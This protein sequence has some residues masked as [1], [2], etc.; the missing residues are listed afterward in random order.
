MNWYVSTTADLNIEMLDDGSYQTVNTDLTLKLAEEYG[1]GLEIAE[2]CMGDSL[3]KGFLNTDSVVRNKLRHGKAGILHAPFN[4]LFPC[5]ID[6][7]AAALAEKRYVQAIELADGYGIPKVVIHSGYAPSIY[8]DSWFLEQSVRFWKVFLAKH[9]F[10]ADICL[11]NVME[12]SP[13]VLKRLME[14]LDEPQIG[15]CLDIGHA[16]RCGKSDPVLWL[17]ELSPW[18]THFHIHDNKGEFD[19]HEAPGKGC[20]DVDGFLK[21]AQILCPNAT[22]TIESLDASNACLWLREHRYL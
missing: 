20:I 6:E 7:E 12:T 13:D 11:E 1:T 21:E 10:Q 8:F 18:L 22:F 5:A 15:L 16:Y 3:G 4:E 14:A 19:T 2:Y 17:R 9:S